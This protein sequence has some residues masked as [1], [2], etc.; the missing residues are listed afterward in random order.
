[1]SDPVP[2]VCI[3][4]GG[5]TGMGQET[6]RAL[7]LLGSHVIIACRSPSKG[8]RTATVLSQ[9]CRDRGSRGMVTSATVDLASLTSVRAFATTMLGRLP[10]L[11]ALICNAGVMTP[12]YQKTEDGFELQFQANYLAHFLLANLLIPLMVR[13]GGG[14]L[15]NVSSLS[16]EKGVCNSAESFIEI[17]RC[18]RDAYDPMRSYRESKLAQV[19]FTAEAHHRFSMQGLATFAVHPGVV[20]TDLFYRS[21]PS[22]VKTLIQPLAWVGYATG[23]LRTP[24]QGAATAIDLATR[25]RISAEEEGRYW[26]D[27]KPRAPNPRMKDRELC[28]GLWERSAELVGPL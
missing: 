27:H 18:E 10:N 1:M 26:A 23:T 20:N 5:N 21:M 12:P 17:G 28:R 16:S 19:L 9:Q 7:A 6:A 2:S 4:T 15:I 8:E 22:W 3:I 11:D 25:A 14:R 24:V 13:S